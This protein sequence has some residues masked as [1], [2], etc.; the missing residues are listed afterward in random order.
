[1][2]DDTKGGLIYTEALKCKS[3]SHQ[4]VNWQNLEH[5]NSLCGLF[6]KKCTNMFCMKIN[7]NILIYTLRNILKVKTLKINYFNMMTL[8]MDT[9]TL[10]RYLDELEESKMH[11]TAILWSSPFKH[12][13]QY[14]RC[15]C[16][17]Y[18]EVFHYIGY[19]MKA[20]G[21]WSE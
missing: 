9:F 11:F 12:M 18:T 3:L 14:I 21:S 20:H 15:V 8:S 1:M 5:W 2:Y 4:D 19:T 10:Y 6:P 16:R 17:F 7:F 13:L